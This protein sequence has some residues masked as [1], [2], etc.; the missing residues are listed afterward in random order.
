MCSI[1]SNTA[2]IQF[3]LLQACSTLKPSSEMSDDL[4]KGQGLTKGQPVIIDTV[5]RR[6]QE[7][8]DR[9]RSFAPKEML[10]I[11]VSILVVTG[12]SI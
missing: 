9:R 7:I 1:E 2:Q 4:A 6:G 10:N 8:G 5:C 3:K 11:V 12:K